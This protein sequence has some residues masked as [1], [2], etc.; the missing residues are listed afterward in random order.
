MIPFREHEQILLRFV[1]GTSWT[2]NLIAAQEKTAVPFTPSHVEALTPDGK[3]Y[4]GARV[5]EGVELQPVGYDKGKVAKLPAGY[6][7]TVFPD[8]LCDL[9]LKLEATPAQS[10]AFYAY[11]TS[12]IGKPYDWLS[13]VGFVVPEH[14]HLPNHVICSALQT[15]AL[16][17]AGWFPY[18][19][20]APAHLVDPRDLLLCLSTHTQIQGV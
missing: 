20:A 19:L 4:L 17:A 5:G 10:R 9:H 6:D 15:L 1:R 11:L 8:G 13:I 2:S 3:S 18:R 16:R 7:A 14:F 12:E